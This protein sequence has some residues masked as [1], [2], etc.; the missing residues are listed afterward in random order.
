MM[1]LLHRLDEQQTLKD[2]TNIA[3]WILVNSSYLFWELVHVW[4]FFWMRFIQLKSPCNRNMFKRCFVFLSKTVPKSHFGV[5]VLRLKEIYPIES[6]LWPGYQW[7]VSKAL[8]PPNLQPKPLVETNGSPRM[9]LH[10]VPCVAATW[11]GLGPGVAANSKLMM[12]SWHL[13]MHWNDVKEHVSPLEKWWAK[14]WIPDFRFLGG[15]GRV[16]LGCWVRDFLMLR[17]SLEVKPSTFWETLC[18]HGR[19]TTDS[20]GSY[21]SWKLLTPKMF[22][23]FQIL[24]NIVRMLRLKTDIH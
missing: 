5:F 16:F 4:V 3:S 2:V 7:D 8:G 11:P 22:F 15:G 10:K 24:L 6:I 13:Q 19:I 18:F 23:K 12:N 14:I 20:Q 9:P 1:A 17:W 21:G